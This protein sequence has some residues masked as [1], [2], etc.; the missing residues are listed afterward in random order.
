[1]EEQAM[2]GGK[3]PVLILQENSPAYFLSVVI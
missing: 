3:L 2:S 1:M